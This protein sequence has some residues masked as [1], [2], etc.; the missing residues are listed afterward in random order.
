MTTGARWDRRFV[1][2]VFA[3]MGAVALASSAMAA[4]VAAGHAWFHVMF[5]L[6]GAVPA[7]ILASNPAPARWRSIAIV[8][9]E[10]LT[11]TQLVEA[12]GAWGFGP[13]NDTVVSPIKALHDIGVVISPIGLIGA[14]LGVALGVAVA[15]RARGQSMI[16]IGAAGAIAVVGLVVVAKMIGM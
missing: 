4:S 5:G 13:D 3:A 15:L 6:I 8:G 12:V 1:I 11:I 10:L 16:A 7:A 2:T 14:V 9:L